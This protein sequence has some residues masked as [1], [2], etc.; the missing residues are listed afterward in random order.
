MPLI[1][2]TIAEVLKNTIPL[3]SQKT[4]PWSDQ[5]IITYFAQKNS[6]YDK[7][8]T[9]FLPNSFILM[10]LEQSSVAVNLLSNQSL[11]SQFLSEFE[12]ASDDNVIIDNIIDALYPEENANRLLKEI[13]HTHINYFT[14]I[15]Y[16]ITLKLLTDALDQALVINN[17]S[18]VPCHLQNTFDGYLP[19]QH[20]ITH[21]QENFFAE[22][23]AVEIIK[24]LFFKKTT[25]DFIQNISL[26]IHNGNLLLDRNGSALITS[27]L[28]FFYLDDTETAIKDP[29]FMS[30]LLCSLS[31]FIQRSNTGKCSK[32]FNYSFLEEK[33]LSKEQLTILFKF[34]N[35]NKLNVL[36]DRDLL[37]NNL[38]LFFCLKNLSKFPNKFHFYEPELLPLLSVER[39]VDIIDMVTADDEP[40]F[41]FYAIIKMIPTILASPSL[42]DNVTHFL[43]TIQ[44]KPSQ[45]VT[46]NEKALALNIQ[47]VIKTDSI[48]LLKTS[49][50]KWLMQKLSFSYHQK[51]SAILSKNPIV[52]FHTI[53][54]YRI[55]FSHR[56]ANDETPWKDQVIC[57]TLQTPSPNA[58]YMTREKEGIAG[59]FSLESA[60]EIMQK[61]KDKK[62]VFVER[63]GRT[64]VF[65]S[66][67]DKK[68][69]CLKFEKNTKDFESLENEANI[70]V[71]LQSLKNKTGRIK[72]DIPTPVGLTQDEN[73]ME[74]FLSVYPEDEELKRELI[75]IRNIANAPLHCYIFT[76]HPYYYRHFHRIQSLA[77]KD[78]PKENRLFKLSLEIL[79][80]DLVYLLKEKG[81][82]NPT[83][84]D[85]QHECNPE[86]KESRDDNGKY[87][88]LKPLFAK[89]NTAAR[90]AGC[91]ENL[92]G[93]IEFINAALGCGMRDNDLQ[94]LATIAQ[95]NKKISDDEDEYNDE[96][97]NCETQ[98]YHSL[99]DYQLA[100][101]L[102]IAKRASEYSKN[103][104]EASDKQAIWQHA[105]NLTVYM[106]A[107]FLHHITEM[108]LDL[109]YEFIKNHAVD[110]NQ[111]A[112]QMAFFWD[113]EYIQYIPEATCEWAKMPN[114]QEDAKIYQKWQSIYGNKISYL[115]FEKPQIKFHGSWDDE[116]G[117]S[118][119]V[120]VDD[121]NDPTG[122]TTKR[123]PVLGTDSGSFPILAFERCVYESIRVCQTITHFKALGIEKPWEDSILN[124]R[125]LDQI[126]KEKQLAT[127]VIQRRY[128]EVT[129]VRKLQVKCGI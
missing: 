71:Y 101:F 77:D 91:I 81:L 10:A 47:H 116:M 114:N 76:A 30:V 121:L 119:E 128:R 34:I 29:Y 78:K 96:I 124:S 24:L 112:A 70:N 11:D 87:F 12:N 53:P 22:K 95:Q 58:L 113:K 65:K 15:L 40:Y 7:R 51:D 126:E 9:G 62:L 52:S 103:K 8:S 44:N 38:L 68:L 92:D 104:T 86:T 85:L 32:L 41:W 43:N 33:H 59:H 23:R 123:V 64:L 3:S 17:F 127:M 56:K 94:H 14:N 37:K 79:I 129:F 27:K 42:K 5:E 2:H 54:P 67:H 6:Y 46:T 16:E 97:F 88:F 89:Q 26:C 19:S 21:L 108:P 93:A 55:S 107:L 106:M 66:I 100:L 75:Q 45:Y 49:N 117:V 125:T 39:F 84:A 35:E 98:V 72:S 1:I 74:E 13:L 57:E 20:I 105:A 118:V 110:T 63:Q 25:A 4:T 102:T 120:T 69:Y 122:K 99:S 28:F 61:L 80:N 31:F 50:Q 48:Q 60:Q 82:V 73:F 83:F 90:T 115:L 111:L 18:I 36:Y 109:S